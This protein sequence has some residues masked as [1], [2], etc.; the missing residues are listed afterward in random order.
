[1]LKVFA[2]GDPG[3]MKFEGFAK[4]LKLQHA[5]LSEGIVFLGASGPLIFV[6]ECLPQLSRYEAKGRIRVVLEAIKLAVDDL[7][8]HNV[9]HLDIRLP[10]ICFKSTSGGND[11]VAIL[12]DLERAK[13]KIKSILS[14]S[15][16][17]C[18]YRT[19]WTLED[20]DFLQVYWMAL[21]LLLDDVHVTTMSY[22]SM[23]TLEA[24]NLSPECCQE[25]YK[26]IKG[27]ESPLPSDHWNL[28]QERFSSAF[29]SH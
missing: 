1:M 11:L 3:F 10:N 21:W 25:L 15:Y 7:H 27:L 29:G 19:G 20:I 23:D 2:H 24:A 4:K 6:F 9:A 14:E 12:I 28:F 18:M 8:S 22:H 5:L 16:S 17:S 13:N 26:W